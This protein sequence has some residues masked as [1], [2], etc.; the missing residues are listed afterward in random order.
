MHTL[1]TPLVNEGR[2]EVD[3][4]FVGD[5]KSLLQ[6]AS[7]TQRSQSELG[8]RTDF[9]IIPHIDL[10]EVLH[11]MHI[12]SH[13]VSQSMRHEQGMCT[14]SYSL[15]HITF[16]QSQVL[17][18]T[19]QHTAHLQMHLF[20]CISRTGMVYGTVMSRHHDII[21]L[22]LPLGETSTYRHRACKVRAIV[23][24]R[25]CTGIGQHQPALLQQVAM[26]VVV[27]CLAIHRKDG[28]ERHPCPMSQRYS[29]NGTGNQLF[30][31]PGL[32]HAHGRGVHLVT[33]V[34]GTFYLFNLQCTLYR[35][36]SNDSLDELYRHLSGQLGHTDTGQLFQP[37]LVGMA[38]RRQEVNLTSLTLGTLY[39]LFQLG[40]WSTLLHAHLSS[41]LGH[42]GLG[43]HPDNIVHGKVI[44][45]EGLFPTLNIYHTG[46][47]RM[48]DTEEI[49]ERTVLTEMIGI[50]GI[51][52]RCLA[53]AQQQ[54]KTTAYLAAQRFT[55]FFINI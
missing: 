49:E 39:H 15:V 5:D 13:H 11:V 44:T 25:L 2:N 8:R 37:Q 50:I 46:K 18:S 34:T 47:A 9:V 35:T 6:A 28:R 30:L 38:V 20:P 17:Q 33:D 27:Q 43:T 22:L 42:T 48:I 4:R 52:G 36:Q 26:I 51:V 1:G 53:I 40:Q 29:L 32:A 12:Q 54:D 19:C 41:L 21:D 7:H 45:K 10:S 14:G 24:V 31:H 16:H 23:H 55:A 3:A